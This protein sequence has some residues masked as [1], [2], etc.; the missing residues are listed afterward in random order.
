MKATIALSLLLAGM[1]NLQG[2]QARSGLTLITHGFQASGNFPGWVTEMAREITNRIEVA[3]PIYRVRYDHGLRIVFLEGGA[4]S[5]NTAIAGGAIILLDWAEVSNEPTPTHHVADRFVTYLF[6]QSHNGL[7]LAELPIHLIGHSRGGSLISRLAYVLAANGILVDQM[8]TLDPHPVTWDNGLNENDWEVTA[9]INTVFADNY[10]RT[11]AF[12]AGRQVPGA[13][14]DN[15]SNTIDG[16]DCSEHASVHTYYFGTIGLDAVDDGAGCNI[17]SIWYSQSLPRDETGYNFSRYSNVRITRP[18]CGVHELLAGANGTGAREPVNS[19]NQFWPNVGVDQRSSLPTRVLPG[20]SVSIP[21]YFSDRNSQQIV[22]LSVDD[23]TNPYNNQG[24]SAHR[25]IGMA[26]HSSPPLGTIGSST[27]AWVPTTADAGIHFIQLCTTNGR[28]DSSRIRYDYFLKPI[29]VETV[30]TSPN[31]T[32]LPVSAPSTATVGSSISVAFTVRNVGNAA[33]GAFGNRVSL[34]TISYGTQ[35]RLAN[36]P[37]ASLAQGEQRSETRTVFIPFETQPGNYYVT[38]FADTFGEVNEADENNNIGSTTPNR[39]NISAPTYAIVTSASPVA[40]GTTSGDGT[41]SAG[42]TVN[43]VATPN[44]GYSFV[45]WTE[46]GNPVS[47]SA[48]YLFT[49][50]ANRTLTANF[51]TAAV[52]PTIT[53]QP[54]S[55]VV[56]PGANMTFTVSATGSPPLSYQWRKNGIELPSET[57]SSPTLNS[58]SP[59]HSGGYS[60]KVSNPYGFENSQVA[61]LTVNSSGSLRVTQGI[62]F[63]EAPP[64]YVNGS[65]T[66]DAV[67]QNVSSATLSLDR[68]QADGSFQNHFGDLPYERSW[69]ATNFSP[70]LTLGPGA[71]YRYTKGLNQNDS[72]NVFPAVPTTATARIYAKFVGVPDLQ[73]VSDAAPGA[74]AVF[75]FEV[76]DR[77]T[78]TIAA[79]SSPGSGG[80]VIGGGTYTNGITASLTATP[81]SGFSFINWTENG[82]PL[83]GSPTLT[84]TVI[85]NRNLQANFMFVAPTYTL[86]VSAT[87]GTVV[88]NPDHANYVLGTQVTLTASPH[89]GFQFGHWDG[90]VTGEDNPLT[91]VMNGNKTIFA[92]FALPPARFSNPGLSNGIFRFTLSGPIGRSF[93]IQVSSNMLNWSAIHTNVIPPD[94]P[95]LIT[96]PTGEGNKFV[97]GV[98]RDVVTAGSNMVLIAAGQFAMGDTNTGGSFDE[99][100]VH[101]VFVSA[102]YVDKY[103]VTKDLWDAVFG[104]ATNH[105][106]AFDNFGSGKA[107]NHPV[108]D[109]NWF[110][111]VKWCN[112]RSE[113]EGLTPVYCTDSSCTTVYRNG[114]INLENSFV[115]WSANGYR[116]CTEAEW[117]KA[118]RGGFQSSRFPFGD[119][120]THIQANYFSDSSYPYDISSTRG[121]HP[122]YAII[123][124]PYTSPVGSFLT[125]G[126]GIFDMAG[127]AREW[128]WDSYSDSWYSTGEAIE[129]DSRGPTITSL[130]VMR[131]GSYATGANQARCGG[132]WYNAPAIRNDGD[133]FRCARSS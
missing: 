66:V 112:A 118:A 107:A 88:K 68:I 40:G 83:G 97:R 32:V 78:F 60:A 61:N 9:Y 33:S 94:G 16:D 49:I 24:N 46:G 43:V 38:V 76:I 4:A 75:G 125:N 69:S 30:A 10:Y 96:M 89:T 58:V 11:G 72:G 44:S 71:T 99:K 35:I 67:I 98:G 103:E 102:F 18:L 124:Y 113:M 26:T 110:D 80:T 54:Q 111:V 81:N 70:A 90:D 51:T 62:Q 19:A 41:Y 84:F 20:Q 130:R 25:Q 23:D 48:S 45:N 27:F 42:T 123:D 77:R 13:F 100:P 64:Y 132:R 8:T 128:C 82:N 21:Y 59:S 3:L 57:S 86:T 50:T 126:Y 1:L 31:L 104:Y 73:P 17:Q 7:N 114:Q 36:F 39:I 6:G 85:G 47:S 101:S 87:N 105:G 65:A 12:P 92:N 34:G 53:A 14:N 79:T 91:V 56:S 122:T 131:G 106:Y 115:R 55:Q 22:I 28:T 117:E 129:D 93:V 5:I 63:L 95:V 15:L 29:T 52:P 74:T 133:G 108:Q 120:I 37:M 121:F 116:L 127:N 109:I 119:T 2:G